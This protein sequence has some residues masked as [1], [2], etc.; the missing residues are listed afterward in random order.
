VLV[1]GDFNTGID[2]EPMRALVSA[3]LRDARAVSESAPE[4]P[5]ATFNEFRMP[6]T[7]ARAIDHVL[8]GDRIRV[9]RHLVL[10]QP[11]DARWPSDH[12]P[13]FVDLALE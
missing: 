13:V 3:G 4:G 8:V 10:A 2:S 9:Q 6:A 1:F 12:F 11:I 7:D 5:V